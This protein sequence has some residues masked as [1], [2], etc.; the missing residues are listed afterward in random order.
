MLINYQ[1][2]HSLCRF[3]AT[4]CSYDLPFSLMRLS[5]MMMMM[6]MARRSFSRINKNF[7]KQKKE[8]DRR[9][10]KI[11]PRKKNWMVD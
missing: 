5:L 2:Q 9:S 8:E 11:F 4:S 6:I 1:S 3:L 7:T 10:S